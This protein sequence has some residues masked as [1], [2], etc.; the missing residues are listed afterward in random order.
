MSV[1]HLFT[2]M[3]PFQTVRVYKVGENDFCY[4]GRNEDVPNELLD[5]S[6]I[7]FHAYEDDIEILVKH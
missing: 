2:A 6:V 4:Q 3:E 7:A 1:R 5:M